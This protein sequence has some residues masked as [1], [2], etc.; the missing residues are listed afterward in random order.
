MARLDRLEAI[1]DAVW[2]ELLRAAGDRSHPW[3]VAVLATTDGQ[4]A[5]ARHVVLRDVDAA[6]RCLLFYTDSRSPKARQLEAFP[7]A[8][9]VLWSALS[10]WQLRLAVQLSLETSG[11]AVSSRWARLKMS[12]AAQDYLSPLPPGSPIEGALPERGS[13]EHFAVVTAQVLAI[14]WLELHAE[15]HRRACFD[16]EGRRWLVP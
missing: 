4:T 15:G 3:R 14:D 13:R 9:L 6:R 7:G 2:T 5:H 10:S 16:G 12:P 11:L 8:T 1:E